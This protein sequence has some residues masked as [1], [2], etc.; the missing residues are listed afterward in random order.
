M[1]S[2][3]ETFN[4]FPVQKEIKLIAFF[5]DACRYLLQ[6]DWESNGNRKSRQAFL[7]ANSIWPSFAA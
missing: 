6:M 7:L 5:V 3:R 4:T 2:K 1:R